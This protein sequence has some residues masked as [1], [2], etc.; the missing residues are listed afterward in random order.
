M[1][2]IFTIVFI[3]LFAASNLLM[4][5]ANFDDTKSLGIVYN[6]CLSNDADMNFL[7]FIGEKLLAAGFE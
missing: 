6:N 3:A 7:E 5:Y 1:K 2:N 4:P